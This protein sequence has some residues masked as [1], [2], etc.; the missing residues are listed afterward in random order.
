MYDEFL[1]DCNAYT[2]IIDKTA[3]TDNINP[4]CVVPSKSGYFF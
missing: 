2:K 1:L 4:S 3:D